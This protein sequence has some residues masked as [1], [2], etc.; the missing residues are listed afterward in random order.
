MAEEAILHHQAVRQFWT[1]DVPEGL[2]NPYLE[3]RFSFW[4]IASAYSIS[5]LSEKMKLELNPK[6]IAR[7]ADVRRRIQEEEERRTAIFDSI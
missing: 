1:R 4:C 5:G 7:D 2:L 6:F 3:S